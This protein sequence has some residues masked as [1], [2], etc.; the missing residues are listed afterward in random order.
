MSSSARP[1]PIRVAFMAL[2]FGVLAGPVGMTFGEAIDHGEAAPGLFGLLMIAC[3]FLLRALAIHL[4]K[5][6]FAIRQRPWLGGRLT[7]WQRLVLPFS[8]ATVI[9]YGLS[10]AFAGATY[11]LTAPPGWNSFSVLALCFNAVGGLLLGFGASRLLV[12]LFIIRFSGLW[13]APRQAWLIG[14]ALIAVGSV[15]Y[16]VHCVETTLRIV[17]GV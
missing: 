1:I 12:G 13:A 6:V 16:A 11:L 10:C 2:A 7:R 15:A 4:E 17:P 3:G 9:T 8:T 14:S 5:L